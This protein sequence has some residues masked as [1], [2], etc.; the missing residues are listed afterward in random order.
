MY[1]KYSEESRLLLFCCESGWAVGEESGADLAHWLVG[2]TTEALSLSLW[3][4]EWND[5]GPVLKEWTV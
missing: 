1:M 4:S 5:M 3:V 2:N